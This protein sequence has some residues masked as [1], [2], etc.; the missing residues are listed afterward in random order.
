MKKWGILLRR[1]AF[2]FMLLGLLL[3]TTVLPHPTY[4]AFAEGVDTGNTETEMTIEQETETG[5]AE[6][7]KALQSESAEPSTNLI[8]TEP[9][10]K[11][12]QKTAQEETVPTVEQKQ[13]TTNEEQPEEKTVTANET[14]PTTEKQTK[15]NIS[16]TKEVDKPYIVLEDFENGIGSWTASGARYHS[17][18]VSVTDEVA[19]FGKHALRMDYDFIGTQGVSGVYASRGEEIVIPGKPKKMGMWVYGDGHKQ[20]LRQQLYDANGT[21]FNIDYTSDNPN[22][23]TWKGWKYVEAEI[24]EHWEAPFTMGSQAVRYMATK[25]NAKTKG[26]IYIDNI[27]AVYTDSIDED[28][29]NPVLS[30]F[31]PGKDEIA[32]SNVPEIRAVAMDEK[33]G[34]GIDPTRIYMKIDDQSVTPA[35]DA[36][37]G[38][39]SY[40]PEK[41][42]AE[43]LHRAWIEVFDKAG[44]HTF[45]TWQFYVS[46][47]GPEV[48]WDGPEEAYAGSTFDVKIKINEP[49]ALTKTELKL[50]Y[51]PQLLKLVDGKA[52]IPSAFN[53]ANVE[54]VV[55]EE[56][57]DISFN[58]SQLEKANLTDS[59]V[60]ATLT[61]RLGLDASGELAIEMKDGYHHYTDNKMGT[62]PFF[63]AP[64]QAKIAQPLTI[65]VEGKS[66]NTPSMIK[67][68]D[69]Y[70]EPVEGATI[71]VLDNKKLIKVTKPTHI[72]KGGSGVAGEPYEAVEVGTYIPVAKVP[73]AGFDYYRIFMPNGE[74][75][76]YHVPKDDVEEIDWSTVFD[77]TDKNGE[78]KTDLL[79]LSRIPL[80]MQATKGELVSQVLD[81]TILPQLGTETPEHVT[82]TWT[83]DP[84]TTQHFT[85]KTNTAVQD[86]VVEVVPAT[87]G[88]GFQSEAVEQFTGKKVL[89]SDPEGEMNIHHVEASG[90]QPGTTYQYRVG[91]GTDSGWSNVNTF[92]TASSE[93][94]P[95]RFMFVA[96]TQAYDE[97]GFALWTQLY[98]LGLEKY[99]DTAFTVH[100]G[101]IVE[102]GNKLSQWNL[103]LNASKGLNE[104]IPFMSVL[105][106]HDVYGTGANTYKHLFPYPQ[107]G[108]EG[109][110]N[111]VYS[112][113]YG[114]AHF[115]MLNS[116]FGVQD[117]REQQEWI[118]Q[119]VE[120]TD[121]LW[122]IVTFH[123]S[124]YKSNPKRGQDATAETFAPLL[125]ELG[126]D[127]VLTGHDHAYMRSHL[128]KNGEPQPDGEGTQYLIG[129]S[130]GPKFY[131]GQETDY[132]KVLH[133]KE[134]Q[135]FTSILV[136][137]NEL[138]I[139]AYTIHDE[140]VDSFTMTKEVPEE[141]PDEEEK[142][143]GPVE[144]PDEGETPGDNNETP[145]DNNN[146]E[147]TPDHKDETPSDKDTTEV[148]SDAEDNKGDKEDTGNKT[149]TSPNNTDKTAENNAAKTNN[150]SADSNENAGHKK[151]PNTATS[152]YHWIFVGVIMTILGL[153]LLIYRKR[154]YN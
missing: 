82:L 41:P 107:N 112:F 43:G 30:D 40:T 117:M 8:E 119:E 24:P 152:I 58:W 74:Q 114:N 137:G 109:K 95:F 93:D 81:L 120:N 132:V 56:T 60:F 69:R 20:W 14:K 115:I 22:G 153:A 140:L 91:D 84:Q 54:Q 90:L 141:T 104:N 87:D 55:N 44:N 17:V 57:G 46:T 147:E 37:T 92:T 150:P 101:D 116:E 77:K 146:E 33:A 148:P 80:R 128:I 5:G 2:I 123:R 102:E 103:F 111:F 154:K 145:G 76:Y 131:P 23:V 85:W 9:G 11:D 34:S 63:V 86:S 7:S 130:A 51:D 134:E 62:I 126:V 16:S 50:H 96:D 79:T 1:K 97:A 38:V 3:F 121:K 61:F 142:P 45:E 88:D 75:R 129:G 122:T 59:E 32:Y 98:K 106:N 135:V 149:V 105:G 18:D 99:P 68:T 67:V 127:L 89:F 64:Y 52:N 143:G 144:T 28:V 71:N 139:E 136:D 48:V 133:A 100:A 94:D 78:V 70:G 125:E 49:K 138:K 21:S 6:S 113:D 39:V 118:R 15:E 29:T 27:R 151:L 12:E 35:Y 108:P 83:N 65:D 47:G 110:E 72:Y 26:T 25:D 13:V 10:K 19:R 53:E 36:K 124:P 73:Y 42:L 4:M 66:V 31:K